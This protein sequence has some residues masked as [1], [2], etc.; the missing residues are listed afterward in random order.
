MQR[1]EVIAYASQQLKIH[2]NNFIS[3]DFGT[4]IGDVC[5]KLLEATLLSRIVK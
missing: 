2:E 5:L 4:W 3:Q 1:E